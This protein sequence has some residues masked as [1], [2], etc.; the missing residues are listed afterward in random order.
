MSKERKAFLGEVFHEW[1]D[2]RVHYKNY[3]H[4]FLREST[5]LSTAYML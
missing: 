2:I 3:D 4:G 1:Q 5:D